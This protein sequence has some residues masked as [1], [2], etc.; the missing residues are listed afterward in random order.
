MLSSEV[1]NLVCTMKALVSPLLF[2]YNRYNGSIN[3]DYDL[4]CLSPWLGCFFDC[5]P[6]DMLNELTLKI[7]MVKSVI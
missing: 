2:K 5:F 3:G 4:N 1:L 7:Y 6:W